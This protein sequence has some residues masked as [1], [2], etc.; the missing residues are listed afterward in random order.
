MP[1]FLFFRYVV[2][3]NYDHWEE[4]PGGAPV[5]GG[6][7]A[8]LDDDPVARQATAEAVLERAGQANSSTPEAMFRLLHTA[9]TFNDGTLLSW[10]ANPAKGFS[11]MIVF[12]GSRLASSL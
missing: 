8:E 5:G 12:N 1:F 10:V 2:E 4:T 11:S 6:G 3:T 9:P 7:A